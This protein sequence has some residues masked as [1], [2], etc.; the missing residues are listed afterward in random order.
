MAQKIELPVRHPAESCLLRRSSRSAVASTGDRISRL[1][2]AVHV[3]NRAQDRLDDRFRLLV[4]SRR[5]WKPSDAAPR[6]AV[7]IRL[8]DGAEKY[9]LA[10]CSV[11]AGGFDLVGACA[12]TGSD[13]EFATLGS[14]RFACAQ[15]SSG[16]RLVSDGPDSRCWRRSASSPKNSWYR[17]VKPMTRAARTPDTSRGGRPMSWRC[18]TGRANAKPTNGSPSSWRT[19]AAHFGWAADHDDLDIGGRG[20]AFTQRS[21]AFGVEQYEPSGGPRNSSDPRAPRPPAAAQLYVMAANA[22]RPGRVD[23]SVRLCR[24]RS[25]WPSK[26]D[27]STRFRMSS[28]LRSA[29]RT[30]LQDTRPVG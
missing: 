5:D 8:A 29:L 27:V 22:M 4:G 25:G 7:V 6:S 14:P 2:N 16:G 15:V 20:R 17:P 30:P 11:F 1:A 3:G 19:C 13:D 28:K 21:S 24:C 9:L 18:G 26:A 12:V 10:R 23:D